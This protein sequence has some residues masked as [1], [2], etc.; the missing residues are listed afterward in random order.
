MNTAIRWLMLL[1]IAACG[2]ARAA[3]SSALQLS[4][5]EYAGRICIELADYSRWYCESQLLLFDRQLNV[6]YQAAMGVQQDRNR[7]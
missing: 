3:Q 5:A 4:P 1:T 2:G 7:K 6:S